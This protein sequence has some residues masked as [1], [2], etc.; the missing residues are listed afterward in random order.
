LA[1]KYHL[2]FSLM[3]GTSSGHCS[4]PTIRLARLGFAFETSMEFFAAASFE[5]WLDSAAHK[6]TPLLHGTEPAVPALV[7][8]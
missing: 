5:N 4:S 7:P 6:V 2:P 1:L 3:M 8:E